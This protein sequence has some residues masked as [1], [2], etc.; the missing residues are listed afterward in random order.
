M[1]Y[2]VFF[3]MYSYFCIHNGMDRIKIHCIIMSDMISF[4][5]LPQ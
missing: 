3:L 2:V 1:E 4:K 5:M